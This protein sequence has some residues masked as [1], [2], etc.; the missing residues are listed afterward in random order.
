MDV[1]GPLPQSQQGNRYILVI[2]D[3][4]TRY[5]EAFPLRKV[6]AHQVVNALIQ[7]ISW[8]GI[9]REIITDQSTNFTSRLMGEVM[10]LLGIKGIKTTPY[11][12]Q[13]DSMTKR[14]NKTLKEML[15]KF[16]SD[17]GSDYLLFA[18][19]EVPQSSSGFSP[20]KLVFSQEVRG[21]L[22]VLKEIW[23][24][25]VTLGLPFLGRSSC[26]PVSL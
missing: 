7:L 23:E 21:P 18:Y 1:V 22:E 2:C 16:V 25:E 6:K 11:H 8:V 12:P 15:K 24:A 20:F 17:T 14:F 13:T 26:E 3:Y 19:R 9:P 10:A 5:P 4:A